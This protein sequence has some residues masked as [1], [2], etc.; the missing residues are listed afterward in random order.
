MSAALANAVAL[1]ATALGNT[2]ANRRLTSGVR[3]RDG[4]GRHHFA[5]MIAFAVALVITSA[6]IGLLQAFVPHPARLL[7]VTVLVAA[8]VLA[9]LVR[10]LL[11]RAWIDRGATIAPRSAS[12]APVR[13]RIAQ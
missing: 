10:F 11:L 6:S 9:T 4:V 2:A 7:E 12:P 13:E 8:N 1:L 3:G 5:G